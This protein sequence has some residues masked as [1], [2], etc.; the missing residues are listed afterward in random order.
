MR[1]L[2]A[3]ERF[4]EA[5]NVRE[6]LGDLCAALRR[7]RDLDALIS[8][9]RLVVHLEHGEA[10]ELRHGVLWRAWPPGDPDRTML[11]DDRS[12]AAAR[13]VEMQPAELPEPGRPVPLVLADELVVVSGW[14]QRHADRVRLV[15]ADSPYES[16]WPGV[17]E[18][19][20]A[21]APSRA[22]RDRRLSAR[23]RPA[24]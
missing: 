16:A 24:A 7:Q 23:R 18:V 17:A 12:D 3:A 6:R 14:L 20:P 4:E 15:H 11:W 1:S 10:L 22:V 9:G 2:A 19:R 5:T 13:T 21:L 8:S